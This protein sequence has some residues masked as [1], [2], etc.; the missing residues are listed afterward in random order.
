MSFEENETEDEYLI[1]GY[2]TVASVPV[3][4]KRVVFAINESPDCKEPYMQCSVSYGD[5]FGEFKGFT[6]D[7]YFEAM[8]GFSDSIIEE[9]VRL[10]VMHRSIGLDDVSCL[11]AKDVEPVSWEDCIAD[12]VV[13]IKESTLKHGFKDISHQLFY[14]DSGFGVEANSRGR[15]CYGWDL[16]SRK[17]TCIYRPEVL[18]VVPDEKLPDFAKKTLE[19]IRSGALKEEPQVKIKKKEEERS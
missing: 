13:A 12:K 18:G 2:K 14:V 11:S 9:T 8:R 10:E 3:G 19:D 5:L 15:A 7:N 4:S 1:E 16:Y 17:R 6:Y